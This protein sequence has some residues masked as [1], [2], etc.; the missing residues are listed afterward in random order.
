MVEAT[1]G[2][3]VEIS[4]DTTKLRVA[5]AEAS[6][7]SSKFASDLT[8]AFTDA[9]LKGK[10]LSDVLR[11]LALSL[12]QH[13]MEAALSPLTKLFGD[14]LNSLVT[15]SGGLLPAKTTM[16]ASGGVISSPISFPLGRG[17]GVAGEAGPEA[18]MPLTRGPDGRLGVKASG[19]ASNV[20]VNVNVTARDA[21]SFRRSEGQIASMM[22][23][24]IGRGTRNL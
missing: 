9:T 19:A 4:G 17:R 7:A 22:H 11:Q 13:A 5:L 20:T 1:E 12:S 2:V 10:E 15:G 14:T 23:R 16:F 6:S 21:E 3:F 18:I 24:A 8:H